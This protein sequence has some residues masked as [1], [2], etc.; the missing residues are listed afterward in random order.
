MTNNFTREDVL[1]LMKEK[2]SFYFTLI[3]NIHN[4]YNLT[5]LWI[6]IRSDLYH[7]AGSGSTSR[8][9]ETDPVWIRVARKNQPKL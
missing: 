8:N 6:R 5:V 9:H 1:A 7:L 4:V 3:E 2:V